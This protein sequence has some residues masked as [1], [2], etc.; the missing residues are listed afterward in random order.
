MKCRISYGV[1]L[2]RYNIEKN[3]QM[4]I[5]MIQKRYTYQY[6]NFI[7]GYYVKSNTKYLQYLFDNMTFSEKMEILSMKF[8]RMWYRMWLIDPE[9]NQNNIMKQDK[10]GKLD[11]NLK[12]YYRK[13]SKFESNFLKDN[14]RKLR[15]LMNNSANS[16]A[17]WEIP[18]G[19]RH[20]NE[21]HLD[22]AIREF[23]EETD[24][25]SINYT[26][27]WEVKPVVISHIDDNVLYKYVYYIAYYNKTSTWVPKISFSTSSQIGEIEQIKWVGLS[28]IQFLKLST[29]CEK[30][31][32]SIFK[33]ISKSFKKCVKSHYYIV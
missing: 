28:E 30:K 17:P 13:K 21:K 5:L 22:C 11:T 3:N 15:K 2:C 8:N 33:T 31:I 7:F 10:L 26:I 27:L 25:K 20:D 1:A 16:V 32:I 12:C 14:G 9:K 24:I 19:T 6:F 29:N 4:E 23:E 18:K